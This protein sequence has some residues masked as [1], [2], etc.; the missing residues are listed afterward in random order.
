MLSKSQR[1]KYTTRPTHHLR[2]ARS[3]LGTEADRRK[4]DTDSQW[5]PIKNVEKHIDST[6]DAPRS[7]GT[8]RRRT[9]KKIHFFFFFFTSQTPYVCLGE[10]ARWTSR[11][12]C[13]LVAFGRNWQ[14]RRRNNISICE[15]STELLGVPSRH[16]FRAEPEPCPALC[17][18]SN[19]KPNF[20]T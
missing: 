16:H 10:V 8:R 13:F 9:L 15:L 4:I 17:D 3:V 1:G 18:I 6:R 5:M 2:F 12:A 20:R 14:Q 11:L 7:A 19:R